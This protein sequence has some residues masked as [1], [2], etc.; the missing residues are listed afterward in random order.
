MRF[1]ASAPVPMLHSTGSKPLVLATVIRF[2]RSRSAAP[3]RS[4]AADLPLTSAVTSEW[5]TE[6]TATRGA[7]LKRANRASDRT[8]IAFRPGGASE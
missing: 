2:A 1:I 4:L 5:F 6:T 7:R 8:L 3:P